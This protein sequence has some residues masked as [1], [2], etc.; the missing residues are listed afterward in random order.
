MNFFSFCV[1]CVFSSENSMKRNRRKKFSL[2]EKI[3]E[4]KKF[5]FEAQSCFSPLW[6][7]FKKRGNSQRKNNAKSI[8]IS[9]ILIFSQYALQF[10]YVIANMERPLNVRNMHESIIEDGTMGRPQHLVDRGEKMRKLIPRS[11]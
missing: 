5:S 7:V 8:S 10:N 9:L 6:A 3:S 1:F 11:A 2:K 4:C